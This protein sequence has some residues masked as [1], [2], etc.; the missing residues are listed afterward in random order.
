MKQIAKLAAVVA[1]IVF[2][3]NSAD[4][5]VFGPSNLGLGSYPSPRCYEPAIPYGNDEYS[6]SSFRRQANEYIDCINEYVEAADNDVRRI[7]DEQEEAIQDAE[8]FLSR[9]RR[10]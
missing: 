8:N 10:Y 4:A 2:T 1:L 3:T 9:V 5:V 7:R 6:W